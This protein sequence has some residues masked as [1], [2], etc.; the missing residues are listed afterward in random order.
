VLKILV[1]KSEGMELLGRSSCRWEKGITTD[2]KE[3]GNKSVGCIHLCQDR[4][5][6][7][8]LVKTIIEPSISIRD[9]EFF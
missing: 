8:V 1:R 4:V 7:L 5:Q 2:I 6:W 3:I 9:G